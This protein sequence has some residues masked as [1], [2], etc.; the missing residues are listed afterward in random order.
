DKALWPACVYAPARMQEHMP[1]IALYQVGLALLAGLE[2]LPEALGR[3]YQVALRAPVRAERYRVA[4]RCRQYVF[5][6]HD[7]PSYY[8]VQQLLRPLR[9]ARQIVQ[10]VLYAARKVRLFPVAAPDRH[11]LIHVV[12]GLYVLAALKELLVAA[13]CYRVGQILGRV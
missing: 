12:V 3:H 6:H 10:E 1:A 13:R 7:V 11:D 2:H 8:H 4:P 9:R 5:K